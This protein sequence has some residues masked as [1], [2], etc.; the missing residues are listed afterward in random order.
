MSLGWMCSLSIRCRIS[1]TMVSASVCSSLCWT[2]RGRRPHRQVGLEYFVVAFG[3]ERNQRVGHLKNGTSTAIVVFQ[4][5][6]FGVRPIF[7]KAQDVADIGT[8]PR[9][10]RLVIVTDD[11]QITVVLDKGFGDS[12]L[13]SVG[14][15]VFIDKDV[16]VL[17]RFGAADIVVLGEQLFGEQQ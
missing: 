2:I 16:I 13:A 12:V 1:R 3:V 5:D 8:P 15:L 11:T 14:V 17:G 4:P 7:R 10:N 9:I 6:H